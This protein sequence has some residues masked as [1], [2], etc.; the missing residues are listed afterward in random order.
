VEWYDIES[1]EYR[2]QAGPCE[3][4]YPDPVDDVQCWLNAGHDGEHMVDGCTYRWSTSKSS[5]P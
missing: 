3:A 1:G 4:R 5:V 2:P